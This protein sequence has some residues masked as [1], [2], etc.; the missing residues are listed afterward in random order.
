MIIYIYIHIYIYIYI[1]I[2]CALPCDRPAG[3]GGADPGQADPAAGRPGSAGNLGGTQSPG[4]APDDEVCPA[5]IIQEVLFKNSMH[6][7]GIPCVLAL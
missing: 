7:N 1:Y 5:R 3:V 2:S 6:R 4:K